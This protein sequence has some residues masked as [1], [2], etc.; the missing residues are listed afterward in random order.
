MFA[1]DP[2]KKQKTKSSQ[3]NENMT[4]DSNN[5]YKHWWMSAKEQKESG[6]T[7]SRK[8]EWEPLGGGGDGE[9]TGSRNTLKRFKILK[10]KDADYK[11]TSLIMYKRREAKLLRW[12]LETR[13]KWHCGF[14][15]EP[16]TFW[17]WKILKLKLRTRKAANKHTRRDKW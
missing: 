5:P 15:K 2:W 9:W 10:W 17:N 16:N 6:P 11:T 3:E 13:T 14:G 1:P 8:Q 7:E 12:E 4:L